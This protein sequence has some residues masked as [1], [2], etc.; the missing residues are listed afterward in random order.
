VNS[1]QKG[2]NIAAIATLVIIVLGVILPLSLI[3]VSIAQEAASVY[4]RIQSG[5]LDLVGFFQQFFDALP[6]W[7]ED[8][9][10]RIGLTSLAEAQE[11]LASSLIKGSPILASGALDISQSAM[12]FILNLC[13]MLYLLFFLLRDEDALVSKIKDAIPLYLEQKDALFRKFAIVIRA[14]VKGDFLVALLQGALGG[15]IF[16][17]LGVNAPLLW[18]ASMAVLSLVPAFGSALVWGPVAVYFL[19]IGATWKGIILFL[20][21][22]FVIGLADNVIRPILVGQDTKMPNYV[23]LIS[24]LGGI[25]MFGLKGLVF[26]PVIAAMFIAVWDIYFATRL[27][28]NR[29]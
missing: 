12:S 28:T 29:P 16:W 14:T 15:L 23:V 21:G 9:M 22:A 8:F 26:G 24:T 11:K 6:P 5:D 1:M 7:A 17:I 27:R 3:G 19:V 20:Y 13:V 25:E 18:A 2:S 10:Q 4:D